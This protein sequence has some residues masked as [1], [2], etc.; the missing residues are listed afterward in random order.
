MRCLRKVTHGG[1]ALIALEIEDDALLA[2]VEADEVSCP[3]LFRI[4]AA[5]GTIGAAR[6]ALRA[7]DLD[8]LGSVIRQHHRAIGA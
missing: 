3:E 1:L 4:V 2:A 5:I 7:L 6:V 8:D